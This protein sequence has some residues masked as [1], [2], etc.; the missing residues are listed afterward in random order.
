MFRPLKGHHQ[1]GI[2]KSIQVMQ[3][4]SKITCVEFNTMLLIKITKNVD[5]G[6]RIWMDG[7]NDYGYEMYCAQF[8]RNVLF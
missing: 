1:G 6:L 8:T 7:H 5:Y 2:Y 3:I 4:V